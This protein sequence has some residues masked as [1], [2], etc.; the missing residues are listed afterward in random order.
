MIIDDLG[1]RFGADALAARHEIVFT[2]LG[3][4]GL[5]PRWRQALRGVA[6]LLRDVFLLY[7]A[8]RWTAP[9]PVDA[10]LFVAT[11]PGA[12]GW[13]TLAPACRAAQAAG[14]TVVVIRHPRLPPPAAAGAPVLTL[15]PPPAA[16]L[17]RALAR[18]WRVV[19]RE[20]SEVS[21]VAAAAAAAR[22][23]LWREA[24]GR[25]LT[26]GAPPASAGTRAALAETRGALA[27]H[28]DFDMMSAAALDHGLASFCLQH[29][30][31]TDEFFPA[32]A[33]TQV[34]WGERAA[35]AYQAAGVAAERL[36]IDPL[37]RGRS[38]AA[39][40]D[41]PPPPVGL[42]LV[43]Q[44]HTPVY[45]PGLAERFAVLAREMAR[46]LTALAPGLRILLH[47][48]EARRG[49][50][51]RALV[52]ASAGGAA[53][54]AVDNP[55]HALLTG[56]APPHLVV[57][58]CSTAL[59]DAALAGHYVVGLDWRFD[60]SPAAQA[61]AR[62]PRRAADAAALAALFRRLQ[63]DPEERVRLA[64][65][66]AAWRA[67]CFAAESGAFVRRLRSALERAPELQQEKTP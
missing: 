21:A 9:L 29:G 40:A 47:P 36:I 16:A 65:E 44:T 42:A 35:A 5:R 52:G 46:E 41:P 11:L 38:A 27:L 37:G 57:G 3:P 22:G 39:V 32:Q 63:E 56:G 18:A 7:R 1:P 31:P 48:E 19:G 54:V 2:A 30:A 60:R 62:P 13:E 12:N 43:S 55:P 67:G 23:V 61:L 25:A 24:W 49:H 64:A 28:N 59:I 17:G 45:G 50:P 4:Q 14:I 51:Y 20:S 34:V 6:A 53:G 10:A 26:T 66:T 33:T 8:K 58:F 15:P